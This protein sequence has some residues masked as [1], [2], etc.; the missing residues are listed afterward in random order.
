MKPEFTTFMSIVKTVLAL[1]LKRRFDFK[2]I[3]QAFSFECCVFLSPLF[4]LPES[5]KKACRLAVLIIQSMLR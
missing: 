5:G 2:T 4:P 1:A 3:K